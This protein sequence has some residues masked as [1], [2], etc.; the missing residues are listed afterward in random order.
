M[1]ITLERLILTSEMPCLLSINGEFLEEN[2][3]DPQLV[4]ENIGH[5]RSLLSGHKIG[6]INTIDGQV[7][8]DPIIIHLT[9]DFAVLQYGYFGLLWGRGFN[10]QTERVLFVMIGC[11][12]IL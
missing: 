3:I 10:K 12:C 8:T 11:H 7:Q 5:I 9:T 1:N 4:P 2:T 6:H